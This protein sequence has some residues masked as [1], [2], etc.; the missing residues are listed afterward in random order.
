VS[1]DTLVNLNVKDP[2]VVTTG[3]ASTNPDTGKPYGMSFPIV[4]AR[5]T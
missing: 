1:S 4:T 5:R 3:P 2:T